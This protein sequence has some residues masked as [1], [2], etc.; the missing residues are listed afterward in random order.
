MPVFLLLDSK[1]WNRSLKAGV[2]NAIESGISIKSLAILLRQADSMPR[3]P[4]WFGYFLPKSATG[5]SSEDAMIE[6]DAQFP[7]VKITFIPSDP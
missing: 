4:S 1:G 3:R 7:M 5:L 2:K 6:L